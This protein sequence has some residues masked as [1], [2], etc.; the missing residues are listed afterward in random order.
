MKKNPLLYY[1]HVAPIF[2]NIYK[3]MYYY[4]DS[5]TDTG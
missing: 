5:D 2:L 4:S 1:I 3:Y